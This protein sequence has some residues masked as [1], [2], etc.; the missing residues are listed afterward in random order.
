MAV[1]APASDQL[2]QSLSAV[3]NG[4]GG[5]G[6]IK[7]KARVVDGDEA[8]VLDTT[9]QAIVIEAGAPDGA[10]TAAV[11]AANPAIAVAFGGSPSFYAIDEFGGQYIGSGSAPE[12]TSETIAMTVDLNQLSSPGDLLLGL[13]GG[14]AIGSGFSELTITLTA[15][16]N[17][18]A[19]VDQTFT[20]LSA[21]ETY[22]TD[23]PVNLGPVGG[24]AGMLGLSVTVTLTTDAP[25]SGFYFQLILGD[26]PSASH[27]AA[28]HSQ[29]AAAMAGMG[30]SSGALPQAA[31]VNPAYGQSLLAPAAARFA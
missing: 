29:F 11:L 1:A 27:G 28:R 4:P 6:D 8:P 13:F 16:N 5:A 14:T 18:A 15:N 2:V 25:G 17:P 30:G 3:A 22:F 23:N 20:S 31:Q 9:A 7:A 10:S 21:A 24:P 19:L 26:P 12:T